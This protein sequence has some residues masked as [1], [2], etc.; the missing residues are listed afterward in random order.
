MTGLLQ[1]RAIGLLAEITEYGIPGYPDSFADGYGLFSGE[2]RIQA[3]QQI[4]ELPV[5]EP[6]H[7]DEVIGL[8]RRAE[9]V[10]G[11]DSRP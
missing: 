3:V 11:Q 5:I 2:G 8:L 9:K 6:S 7:L 10:F 1:E 4:E